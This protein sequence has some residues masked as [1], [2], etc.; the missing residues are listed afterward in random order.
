MTIN[1]EHSSIVNWALINF[2]IFLEI[3]VCVK[4]S[5][6]IKKKKKKPFMTYTNENRT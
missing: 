1:D 5:I 2:K 6:S 4:G 3:K